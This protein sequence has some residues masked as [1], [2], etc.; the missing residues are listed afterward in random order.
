MPQKTTTIHS[1]SQ[2]FFPN[3]MLFAIDGKIKSENCFMA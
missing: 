3:T 2:V 1:D